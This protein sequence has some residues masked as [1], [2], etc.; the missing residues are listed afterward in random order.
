M[1]KR[2]GKNQSQADTTRINPTICSICNPVSHCGVDA[3]VRDEKIVR[4]KGSLRAHNK[5]SLCVKG[6]AGLDYV[7][8][9]DRIQTPLIRSGERGDGRFRSV[10]WKEA[11]DVVSVRLNTVKDETG[12]ESVVFYAGYP[13]WMRPFLKRLTHSFGSPNYMSES[14]TCSS[15]VK[16]ASVLNYGVGT[17]PEIGKCKCLLVWS[18]NPFHSNPP[19]SKGILTARKKGMKIIEVG[20]LI[21]PLT[22][23]AD[24]HLRL[25]PGT[26]GALALAIGHV[27]IRENLHDSDFVEKWTTGFKAYKELAGDFPP[28]TAEKITGVSADL[29]IKAARLFAKTKPSAVLSGASPTVHHTNGVQNHRAITALIGLTGNFDIPGGNHVGVPG[30]LYVSNG[31][32]TR[33]AEYGQS[34]DW[35]QMPP[36][37]GE[38]EHPVW[39]RFIPEAHA[40]V[41]PSQIQN[42]SPYPVRAMLAF[43]LNHRMWPGS[44]AFLESIKGLDFIVGV[45][46]FMTDTIKFAD[47]ILPACSSFERSELKFYPEK[48]IIWTRPAIESLGQSRSDADIIFDLAKTLAPDDELMQ[49]GYEASVNWLLAPSGLTVGDLKKHPEGMV[50]EDIPGSAYRKYEQNGFKTLS[51]KMEF[52]SKTLLDQGF[53]PLPVYQEPLLSPVSTPGYAEEFPLILTTGARLPYFIHSRTWRIPG[54]KRFQPDPMAEINPV[55]AEERGI[56]QNDWVLLSTGR[57]VIRVRAELTPKVPP[58]VVNMYHGRAEADVNTLIDPDYRDPISGFPGYKSL[59]CQV[60]KVP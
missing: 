23:H 52:V 48:R 31:I 47:V 59:L 50:V 40:M 15:A 51:G 46:L 29:I 5:G 3:Y 53:D 39:T 28:E 2:N 60:K 7:Y 55:D 30:Y 22:K 11:L 21:T 44:D 45:D 20:P 8:H 37:I 32:T 43:G 14:S 54:L 18:R 17:G 56:L 4:I 6:A 35:L 9:K 10:S 1:E 36:R 57:G 12:P 16:L 41:L 42:R 24:I 38:N 19:R 33:E 58:G 13:K 27:I 34:R 49:Q 25:R 26:S